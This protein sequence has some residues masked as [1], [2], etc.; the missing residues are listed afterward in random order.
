MSLTLDSREEK[1]R[2]AA[3]IGK[4][5]GVGK[6]TAIKAL[7][8]KKAVDTLKAQGKTTEAEQV[9]AV[10]NKR[11]FHAAHKQ[12]KEKGL[13]PEKEPKLIDVPDQP[14]YITLDLWQTLDA[15]AQQNILATAPRN[16]RDGDSRIQQY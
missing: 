2:A 1:G 14:K 13:L 3:V 16:G 6:D 5:I 12:V 8:V 15:I 11:G 9:V 7:K 4:K 10:L